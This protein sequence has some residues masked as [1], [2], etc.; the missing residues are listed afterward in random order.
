V[1]SLTPSDKFS[2]LMLFGLGLISRPVRQGLALDTSECIC[3]PFSI[4]H[5]GQKKFVSV[6]PSKALFKN[7]G[8]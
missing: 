6:E 8:F 7:P 3:H 5:A 1:F 2:R 4:G